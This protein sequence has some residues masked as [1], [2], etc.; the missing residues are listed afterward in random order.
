LGDAA[1]PTT[2]NLGQG[3]CQAIED[4]VVLADQLRGGGDPATA[5]RTYEKLRQRRTARITEESFRIGRVCQWENPV[6]CWMRDTANRFVPQ[7][8]ALWFLERFFQCD[9]PIL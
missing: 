8:A 5:F 7:A 9:L 1:H 4:A 2:P 3:A 6:G